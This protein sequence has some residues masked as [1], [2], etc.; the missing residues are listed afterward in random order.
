MKRLRDAK[1]SILRHSG[2]TTRVAVP[3]VDEVDGN[4][5][6][7]GVNDAVRVKATGGSNGDRLVSPAVLI[8]DDADGNSIGG[9]GGVLSDIERINDGAFNCC[10]AHEHTAD[11]GG[12]EMSISASPPP[13]GD[14]SATTTV[15]FL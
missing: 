6:S 1:R 2:I 13:C 7:G 12:A 5:G 3:S 8:N 9:A 11:S 14:S 15:P 10:C 4:N